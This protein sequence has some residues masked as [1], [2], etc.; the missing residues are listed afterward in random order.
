MWWQLKKRAHAARSATRPEI[1]SSTQRIFNPLQPLVKDNFS[2]FKL[3]S[4]FKHFSDLSYHLKL[5][6]IYILVTAFHKNFIKKKKCKQ[7][8]QLGMNTRRV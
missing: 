6:S 3:F 1:I 8:L 4:D 5:L 7:H 2:D